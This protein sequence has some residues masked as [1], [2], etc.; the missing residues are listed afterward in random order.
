MLAS[1]FLSRTL[2]PMMSRAILGASPTTAGAARPPAGRP[3]AVQPAARGAIDAVRDLYF[4]GLRRVMARRAFVLVCT[5]AIIGSRCCSCAPSGGLLSDRRRGPD[6]APRPGAAGTRLEATERI[7]ADV[8]E[9]IREV[10]PARD[11]DSISTNTGLPIFFNLAF[12][13]SDNI[14]PQDTDILISLHLKHARRSGTSES[15][16]ASCPCATPV[17]S[18]T[19]RRA[20][21]SARCSTS[22][23]RADRHPGRGNNFALTYRSPRSSRGSSGASPAPPTSTSGRS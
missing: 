4:A 22:A 16:A 7:V 9:T 6:P 23:W 21:S 11:L 5:A 13:Q 19:S 8:E 14:G 15:S 2:V 1:Y 12:V 10:I 17:T 20:T 3:R 18:S